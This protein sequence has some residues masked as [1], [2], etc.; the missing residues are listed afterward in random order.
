LIAKICNAISHLLMLGLME[1]NM[2]G[3]MMNTQL[4]INSLIEFAVK[5][6]GNT[7]IVSRS[8]EGPIHRYSYADSYKRIGK[9]ANAL[10]KLGVGEGDRVATLAWNTYRHFELYFAVSGMGAICHT[11][12]PRLFADQIV[13]ILNHANDK[14]IFVDLTFVP[15]LEAISDKLPDGARVVVM[16]DADHMPKTKIDG[17]SAYEDI[18]GQETE[19]FAW[20]DLNENIASSLCYSSG[21]TG[22][23]KGVL[24]SHR[25]T[26]LHSWA[27]C[28]ADG[29][30]VSA[31]DAVLP[32]VPMFHVNA[33]GLPYSCA[34]AGAKL[35][36]P[37]AGMDGKSV[38]GLLADEGATLAAGVPTVWL[39]LLQYLKDEGV[40]LPRLERVI[41]GGSAVPLSMIEEFE[42]DV[43][44]E[45]IH[46]W[47]MTEMSPLGTV[48][49]IKNSMI[50]KERSE[51]I[52]YRIKQGR[53]VFGIDAKITGDGGAP[54]PHDGEAFGEL[55]VRGPWI[56]GSY[57]ENAEANEGA[58]D[59]E[60]FLRT[61]D[62]STIDLEG[63]IQIVDRSKDV[64]KSGGEWISSIEL[65][66]LAV[67][68]ADVAEAAVI[69][70][71]HEKWGERPLLVC[72]PAEGA[73]PLAE[74]ILALFEGKVAKMC[75]PDA[76]EFVHELPHTA[77][78]KI[79]KTKLR[80]DFKEY[81]LPG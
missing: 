29:F 78:G 73:S 6:H 1:A 69:G 23:P 26:V 3:N 57:F 56:T 18:V 16:T 79:L 33:W 11:I 41:V 65:E 44:A 35:I 61:G 76:V 43:G 15:V 49:K 75:I 36:L 70:I 51:T 21:T 66:N 31:R 60:G 7:E 62:V 58:F 27:T 28:A 19:S 30:A 59:D 38:A 13:Y 48:A 9:L 10:Q 14:L 52:Q 55:C 24:Y 4:T 53:P 54:L 20:P 25:S 74:D 17:A 64:I 12:N 42:N 77:T 63:F 67:G 39:M 34:M 37:G 40:K 71:S 68:H 45:C 80:N 32:V 2:L 47:G 46:A 81:R 8:V 50:G 72:V 22:N 5:F